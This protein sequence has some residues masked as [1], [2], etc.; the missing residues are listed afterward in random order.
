MKKINRKSL[1]FDHIHYRAS[2][3]DEIRSFYVNTMGGVELPNDVLGGNQNLH[4]ELG[5]ATLLFVESKDDTPMSSDIL[6]VYHIAFLVDNCQKAADYY[7]SRGAD[8][9]KPRKRYSDTIV[10]VFLKAPDGMMIEL[11]Q[12]KPISKKRKKK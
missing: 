4:I 3:F 7:C 11:K 9:A 12:I 8:I 10:A 1:S 2:N 5:G 6:G